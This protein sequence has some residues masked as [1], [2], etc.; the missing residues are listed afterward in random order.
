MDLIN[1]IKEKTFKWYKSCII[2]IFIVNLKDDHDEN[3][4]FYFIYCLKSYIIN[5]LWNFVKKKKKL[6]TSV[7]VLLTRKII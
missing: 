4:M 7:K 2:T 6:S 3:F 1:F 5:F